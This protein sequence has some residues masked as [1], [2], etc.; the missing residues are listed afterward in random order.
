MLTMLN[1]S[2]GFPEEAF[3][4]RQMKKEKC[5]QSKLPQ[6]GIQEVNEHD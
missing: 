4:K 2:M 3:E 5:K 1:I 6:R